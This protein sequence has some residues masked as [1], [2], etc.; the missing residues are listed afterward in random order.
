LTAPEAESQLLRVQAWYRDAS[1]IR[2]ALLSGVKLIQQKLG[3]LRHEALSDSLTGLANRRAMGGLLEMLTQTEQPYAVLSLDIDHFKCVND[4]FGHYAGDSALKHIAE[5]LKRNSRASDLACR[6][7]G[8]EFVLIMPGTSMAIAKTI[9]ER[10][11]DNVACSNVPSVG[12][13]TL[14][15]GVACREEASTSDS[16]LKLADE[17]LYVAKQSGRNR[18]V[19]C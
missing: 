16:V 6:A 7:G 13:L 5:I 10:I 14:S 9:A 19:A 2:R 17:R 11:R 18:V 12:K 8:E 4:T 1:A 15:I 3:L